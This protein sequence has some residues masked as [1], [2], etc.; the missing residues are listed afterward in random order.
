MA[1]CR[2]VSRDGQPE[3]MGFVDDR[4]EFVRGELALRFT[5][6]LGNQPSAGHDLDHVDATLGMS[7]NRS[8]DG[9]GA[10]LGHPPKKWQCPPGVVIG[11]PAHKMVGSPGDP[12]NRERQISPIPEITNCRDPP[13]RSGSG[14]RHDGSAGE[15]VVRRMQRGD[16]ISRR[17]EDEVD[18]GVNQVKQ[19][20]HAFEVD[21][22]GV[23][24]RIDPFGDGDDPVTVEQDHRTRPQLR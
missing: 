5:S 18:M 14:S 16:R 13:Q 8:T 4:R 22:L 20:R 6:A 9:V 24:R 10:W 23:L 1:G 19:Q 12:S 2:A 15:I 7:A 3:M 17:V 21:E 11:G